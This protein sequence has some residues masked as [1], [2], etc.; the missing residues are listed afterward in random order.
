MT[1]Y[2]N[3]ELGGEL[4]LRS[5]MLGKEFSSGDLF[6]DVTAGNAKQLVVENTSTDTA[7][8][9]LEPAVRATGHIYIQK[10][11]NPSIDTVGDAT[12]IVSKKTDASDTSIANVTT[13]G[14]GETGV[15]SGGANYPQITAGAGSN[16]VNAFP[17]ESGESNI[18][19]II[20]PGDTLAIEVVNESGA[21]EDISIVAN[22]I[23]YPVSEL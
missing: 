16:P 7:I 13:A 4:P 8:L 2:P 6:I 1:R 9:L 17:G 21:L 18:S 10:T 5:L 20:M 19:D 14:D 22:F 3:Q 12:P 11:E 23:E 15:I